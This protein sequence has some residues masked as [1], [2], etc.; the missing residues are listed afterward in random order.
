[1]FVPARNLYLPGRAL[2][3]GKGRMRVCRPAF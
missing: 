2:E 3:L 1:V